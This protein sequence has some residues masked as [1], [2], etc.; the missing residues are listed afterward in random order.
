[1]GTLRLQTTDGAT[2]G[3]SGEVF[4]CAYSPDGG[5]V[6]SGGWDGYLRAWDAVCGQPLAAVPAAAKPLSACAVSP[7]GLSWLSGSM[8]GMLTAWDPATRAPVWTFMAHTRP[9]SAIRYAPDGQHM[10]TASWD[11]QVAIRKLSREREPRILANHVDIVSGCCFA[12]GGRQLLSW[13]YDGSVRLWNVATGKQAAVLG[14][15]GTRVTA[16]DVSADG[17]WAVTGG[18]DGGLKLWSLAEKGESGGAVLS[19]EV[20]GLFFLPDSSSFLAADADGLLTLLTLPGFEVQDQLTLGARTQC[21]ALAP[22]ADQLA[23]GGEDGRVRFVAVGGF[24][25]TALPVTALQGVRQTSTGFDRLFGRTRQ[26]PTYRFTCP[27]CREQTE[28]VGPAPAGD[29]PCPACNRRLRVTSTVPQLQRQ[30][31]LTR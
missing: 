5:T 6:L 18:L 20:R 14:D 28:C 31:E 24:E 26:L 17:R 16:G 15:H 25:E 8:E 12:E 21:A 4:A 9:V 3:H 11:R 19:S 10:A 27:A 30:S 22:V 2:E 29:F 23:V 7:D 1:V 13:S